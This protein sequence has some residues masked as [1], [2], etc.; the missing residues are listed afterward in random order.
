MLVG[1]SIH[2]GHHQK[3]LV[4]WI[5]AHHTRLGARPSA[6]FSVSLT[7]A[8]DTDEARADAGE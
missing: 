4:E 8:D 7:A 2:A 5:T 6:F 1:G 3:Q